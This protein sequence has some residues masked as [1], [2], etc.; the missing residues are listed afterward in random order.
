MM[1]YQIPEMNAFLYTYLHV[2]EDI[3]M[4]YGFANLQEKELFLKLIGLSGIGP[5]NALNILS[6]ALQMISKSL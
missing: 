4:F 2:R 1:N 6:G 3:L 5:K